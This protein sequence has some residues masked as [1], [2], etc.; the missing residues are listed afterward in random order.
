MATPGR[1]QVSATLSTTPAAAVITHFRPAVKS[2]LPAHAPRPRR[3]PSHPGHLVSPGIQLTFVL[4]SSICF[5]DN[6]MVASL[7]MASAQ[8]SVFLKAFES[9]LLCVYVVYQYDIPVHVLLPAN[10]A[11]NIL[12]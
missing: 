11:K 10:E 5:G 4:L 12:N 7:V 8:R 3:A 9:K 6:F 2:E 1:V